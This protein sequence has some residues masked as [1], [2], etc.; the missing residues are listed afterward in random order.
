MINLLA[1][2]KNNVIISLTVAKV[3]PEHNAVEV[4]SDQV[5]VVSQSAEDD[6][7]LA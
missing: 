3:D 1:L 2:L 7:G 6:T 5:G 4:V